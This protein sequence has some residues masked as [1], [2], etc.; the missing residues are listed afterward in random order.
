MRDQDWTTIKDIF[1]EASEMLPSKRA[2][3][4]NK[5]CGGNTGLRREIESLLANHDA[6]GDEFER[7]AVNLGQSVT[8]TGEKYSGRTFGRF[9]IIREIGSGGM[10][11]VFLADRSD[12]EFRQ[13]IALKV[14][15]NTIVD[16]ET[17]RRFR[18]ERQIL[19]NLNHPNIAKLLDGGISSDGE[20]YLA[21]EYVEGL[22][23][24]DYVEGNAL[25]IEDRLRLF[26]RICSAVSYA[27]QNLTIH[28]DIKPANVIVTSDGEPKLLDFG[29]AKI[30]DENMFDQ[31]RTATVY[32]A[33]TPAY[34]SPEQFLGKNVTTVSDVYSLGV[35]LYELLTGK[36]PFDYEG[37]SLDEI[38]K[39]QSD[40]EPPK[41]SESSSRDDVSRPFGGQVL[42]GDLDNIVVKTLQ[43]EPSERYRS[44]EE[45][46]A[47]I[48]RYLDGRPVA[49]RPATFTYR[50]TKFIRRNRVTVAAA[51]VVVV[52]LIAALVV[53]LWQYNETRK[54]RDLAEQRFNDV[55]RLSNSLLFEIAPRLE[56]LPGSIGAREII[57]NRALEYLD[58]LAGQSVED[59]QLQ[60]E[61]AAAYAKIGDLQGN[62]ANPNFIQLD[63]A[64]KNYEKA[65]GIRRGILVRTP[66]DRTLRLTIAENYRVLGRIYGETNDYDA[67]QTHLDQAREILAELVALEPSS[68]EIRRALAQTNYDAGVGQTSLKS[69]GKALPFYDNAI[70]LLEPVAE[71]PANARLLGT[72]YA[73]KAY[74]LSWETRQSEAEAEMAKAVKIHEALALNAPQTSDVLWLTYWLAGNINEEIDN[75]KFYEYQSKA[76]RLVRESTANDPSDIRAKQ[77]LAKTL[78]HLGQAASNIGRTREALSHLEESS[79][80]YREIIESETRNGRLKADLAGSLLRLGGAHNNIGDL[81]RAL[82]LFTDALLLYEDVNRAF[83]NDKR[84]KNNLATAHGEIAKLYDRNR[85]RL[86]DADGRAREHYNTA[87]SLM[88][89]MEEQQNILSTYD[90][91]FLE[92]MKAAVAALSKTTGK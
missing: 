50:A 7:N 40:V 72:C 91:E 17:A 30:L 81:G 20:P 65:L 10:G 34:A 26:V 87:L 88:V 70:Q 24:L 4:L 18:L 1:A 75:K 76:E 25:S 82:D 69:Y 74:S 8:T 21:M 36:R 22:S 39:T 67:E 27:H 78:S 68:N 33:F 66:T 14:I 63:E 61:L 62:P 37:L 13:H 85:T 79:R 5:S 19:A 29:L 6:G 28:R 31:D 35:V 48:E 52:A 55:R 43:K 59:M 71:D 92:E 49:A 2:A 23:L 45:L 32:R 38:I 9:S 73:Q 41:P 16:K 83:P 46:I 15:R 47:D 11:S 57:I 44:V 60:A 80:I 64:I 3:Y 51:S 12:G 89:E 56:K 84:T 77:R 53:T 54:G 90:L 42:K 86:Q 58:T